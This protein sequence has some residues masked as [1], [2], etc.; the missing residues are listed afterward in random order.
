MQKVKFL[1]PN[2]PDFRCIFCQRTNDCI[3][4]E[5]VCIKCEEKYKNKLRPNVRG[6]LQMK[7]DFIK[8]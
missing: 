6:D 1:I 4:D 3:N 8:G 2:D 7:T 5:G